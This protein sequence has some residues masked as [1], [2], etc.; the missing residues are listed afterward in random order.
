MH[1]GLGPC[2][3]P[4]FLNLFG[5]VTSTPYGRLPPLVGASLHGAITR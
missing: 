3:L 5:F 4:V 1:V 2:P